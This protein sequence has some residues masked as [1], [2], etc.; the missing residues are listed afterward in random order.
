MRSFK[1]LIEARKPS[2]DNFGG[3]GYSGERGFKNKA[4]ASRGGS[5]AG[6][7]RSRAAQRKAQQGMIDAAI[8]QD[9]KEFRKHAVAMSKSISSMT[10]QK[11]PIQNMWTKEKAKA[12]KD[13]TWFKMSIAQ[14]KKIEGDKPRYEPFDWSRTEAVSEAV[15]PAQQAAIAIS[16]KE[17]AKKKLKEEDPCWDGWKQ[18]GMKMK[19]GKRV[20]NCVKEVKSVRESLN[21]QHNL[22]EQNIFRVGSE[23]YFDWFN[24]M[25]DLYESGELEVKGFDKELME[26]D[27]GL[28]AEFEGEIIP[29]DCPMLEEEKD[30]ELNKP[31]AGGPKKYY[32]YVKDPSTGNVKKVTW[33]DTTGLKVKLNDPEARKSFAARHKC[34]QQKDRTSAA[35]WACNLPRYAKQLGLSGGGNFYW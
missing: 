35:Y 11:E 8:K 4:A 31:K 13:G 7:N 2:D 3:A 17:R 20:P 18:V 12:L 26:G 9:K 5:T 15:S 29:L 28:F 34:A 10:R 25:R 16:K 21:I 27:L 14:Q 33:G 6:R 30:V 22:I 24:Q 19:N 1:E 23:N 32:V